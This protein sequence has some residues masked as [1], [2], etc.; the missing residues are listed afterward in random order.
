MTE[1]DGMARE[2]AL[3]GSLLNAQE[4]AKKSNTLAARCLSQ[5]E[6]WRRDYFELR[7]AAS[8]ALALVEQGQTAEARQILADA[9]E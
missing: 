7:E 5:T 8:Q 1:W 3:R 6:R 4:E 9:L 2:Q